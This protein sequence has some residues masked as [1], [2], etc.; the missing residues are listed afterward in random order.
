MGDMQCQ[1]VH[2]GCGG[3]SRHGSGNPHNAAS[4]LLV[5]SRVWGSYSMEVGLHGGQAE[6]I[7]QLLTVHVELLME[8]EAFIFFQI[9]AFCMIRH[10][11]THQIA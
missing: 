5:L 6:H 1:A 4:L 7:Q 9:S 10:D 11:S 3:M 8:A 2:A